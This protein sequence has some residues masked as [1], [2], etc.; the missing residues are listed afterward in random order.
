MFGLGILEIFVIAFLIIFIFLA[1]VWMRALIDILKS[2]FKNN[3]K[4]I[5]LL[6][7]IFVPFAG[8]IIYFV[9]GKKQKI[10]A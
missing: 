5:W 10:G 8:A 2:D 1:V 6:T 7:V 4:L 3:N 9:I